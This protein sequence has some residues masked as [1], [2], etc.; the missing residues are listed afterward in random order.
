MSDM[1]NLYRITPLEKKSIKQIFDLYKTDNDGNIRGFEIYDHYRWG[2]GFLELDDLPLRGV[3]DVRCDPE[4]GP[5][6]DLDDQVALFFEFDDSFSEEEQ[7]EIRE[8]YDCGGSG[9]LFDGDH[10]WEIESHQIEIVGP[11][12]I[13][14]VDADGKLLEENIEPQEPTDA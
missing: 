12:Q 2:V 10:G 4:V 11:Y 8:S 13:D 3:I 14:L 6:C 7:E 9:W 5:G 1:P